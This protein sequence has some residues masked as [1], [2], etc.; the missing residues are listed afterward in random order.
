M[1]IPHDES[2]Y[3]MKKEEFGDIDTDINAFINFGAKIAKPIVTVFE[4][5]IK[6]IRTIAQHGLFT[7]SHK[8]ETRHDIAIGK[9]LMDAFPTLTKMDQRLWQIILTPDLKRHL[10]THLGKLG[11]TAYTL[12]PGL[13]GLGRSVTELIET[14]HEVFKS[15]YIKPE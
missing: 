2:I 5:K 7:L 4:S 15:D 12:F 11:I 13:D 9:M 10:R 8:L 1:T 6:S 3:G 14:H